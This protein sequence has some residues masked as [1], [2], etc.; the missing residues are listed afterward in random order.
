[1]KLG[2]IAKKLGCEL[3]GSNEV[4]INGVAG[5]E[6]AEKEDLTFVSNPKYLPKIEST[7]AGAIIL[8]ADAPAT[9]TPTLISENPYLAFAQA[10]ELF[11][12]SP[13][14]VPGI[15]PTASIAD[16][17][18]L[19]GDYSI[20]ANVVI[21]EGVQL[22][23]N[24]LLYPNVTIY[25]HAEIGDDLIAHSNSVIR[26]YCQVGNR[27]R[28]A[29]ANRSIQNVDA[30]GPELGLDLTDQSRAAGGKIDVHRPRLGALQ[31]SVRA[32]R[33]RLH[34]PGPG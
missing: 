10:I 23:R 2:K 24:A 14:P 33:H 13:E 22:G 26:E 8:S 30:F 27:P 15:H 4:E 21:G 19:K 31:D 9:S 29:T 17:V 25:P 11:Y 5:I 18:V 16:D 1:M 34:L 28:L 20:G 32:Q 3:R 12:Q 7:R 6:E